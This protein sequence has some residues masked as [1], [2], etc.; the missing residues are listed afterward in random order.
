MKI[1]LI[2]KAL[3]FLL[4]FTPVLLMAQQGIISGVLNDNY[5]EPIPGVNVLVKG[6]S[7]GVTTDFD[8]IYNIECSVGDILVFS[9]V[10]MNTREVEVNASMF[11][12]TLNNTVAVKKIPVQIIESNAYKK[13]INNIKKTSALAPSIEDS[14]KTYNKG[15]F[16]LFNRISNIE[17]KTDKVKLTYFKPDTYYEIGFKNIT[18]LQFVKNSNLP[19]LQNN[20]AQGISDNGVLRFQGPEIGN[21]FSYGPELNLLE[22]DNSDYNYDLN[23]RLVLT[24]NGNGNSAKAYNNSI[25]NTSLKSVNNLFF[26]I[27]TDYSSLG[28]DVTNTSQ[29]DT[30]NIENNTSN[31]IT[32]HYKN[33]LDS[34]DKIGWDTFIKYHTYT[35]NQPNINGFQNNVLLNNWVTPISFQNSQGYELQNGEQRSF[36]P[37]NYN[38]PY[39]LLNN[40]RNKENNG[41]LV[42]SLKNRF[43]ISDDITL[44]TK[45]NYSNH[46]ITQNFGLSKNTIGFNDGYLS[47]RIVDKNNFN[48]ALNFKFSKDY[49]T[50]NLTIFSS[51]DYFYEDL[52]YSLFQANGLDNFTFKNPENSSLNNRFVHRNTLRLSNNITYKWRRNAFTTSIIN[53]SYISSVQDDKWFL[54]TLQF[55]FDLDKLLRI[56]D[57]SE[58]AITVSTSFDVNDTPLL[59]NNQSHNSLIISPEESLSYR[60][61]N[62]LFIDASLKLEEKENY[63]LQ[64]DLRFN[65]LNTHFDI[66]ANYFST[67]T[68]NTVF[69]VIDNNKFELKN[70]ANVKN[71]GVEFS[72][73]SNVRLGYE[74]NYYP[75]LTFSTYRTKVSKLLDN[76]TIVPIAGFSTISKNL[77]EGQPAGVI[78]GSAYARDSQN[79]VIIGS[80]G[81][82][83]VDPE[84]KV[85]GNPIP[86]FNLGFTN[87]FKW[88]DLELNF[89]IDFQ[90]GGDIWNGTQNVLNYFGT[91][92]QSATQRN[93]SNYVFKGVNEQ[94]TVNTTP[95]DFYTIQNDIS[96]NRFVRYGFEGVAEDAIKDGSYVNLKSIDLTYTINHNKKD[97]FIRTLDIGVYAN[98]LITWSKFNGASPYSN[99]YNNRSAKGLNF[100]NAP[101]MSEVGLKMNLKI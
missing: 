1:Q 92:Q 84:K 17:N 69:P 27:T 90:K 32:F 75:S 7:T 2:K 79:N 9:F 78:V 37:N 57:F 49:D 71:Y 13:A 3:P 48:T 50:S 41:L 12:E 42:T 24:G 54:P 65:A 94:G 33:P 68:K 16:F 6:T 76:R 101:L 51:S 100:F 63:E 14:N 58:L 44:N 39:W 5:G 93:I 4:L 82:P 74:F 97:K 96:E 45:L 20:F 72:I 11:G 18:S 83:I 62:D 60:A 22:F 8:G 81:F 80:N 29:K 10:G 40:N 88:K 47:N 30:Y 53:N 64:L 38:N 89:S 19:K 61:I 43:K 87:T 91:S 34:Y 26:N 36:S 59:Y 77:I 99:L 55:K 56:Y 67:E 31:H 35:N 46:K 73:N 86:D 52:N 15:S 66:G 25:F 21:V 95:V 70:V 98:N 85:I 23:G 28:L